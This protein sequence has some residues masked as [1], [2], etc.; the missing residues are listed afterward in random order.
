MKIRNMI[1]AVVI[2]GASMMPNCAPRTENAVKTLATDP[3]LKEIVADSLSR[4][5][6][7]SKKIIEF[8]KLL[9]K[10][11]HNGENYIIVNKKNCKS[12]VYSPQGDT[13]CVS[14]VALGKSIGDK[15]GG[16]Y[17]IRGAVQR[18][19]T[20]PGEFVISREGTSHPKDKKL[21]GDR[22]MAI[23]GD[24]TMQEYKKSQTLALH[25]VPSS[26]MGKLRENVFNNGTIR[27]NR[28]SFGCVNY[29][30]AEFD[31]MRSFIKGKGTKVYI[32]PEEKGNHLRLEKQQ[33][34]SF[35]FFQTK[36]RTEA[37]E[38]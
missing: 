35:K 21:Y 10:Y 19:Y 2:C 26:P 6:S 37:Q 22:V 28:V 15:R 12:V 34:G 23:A 38:H 11:N 27:D 5:M 4:R 13:L 1:S 25:R 9:E 8:N 36:Y 30:P 33:D 16:G 29:M 14:E 24:H 17:G 18:S 31:R 32:L 3:V 7:D 20:T